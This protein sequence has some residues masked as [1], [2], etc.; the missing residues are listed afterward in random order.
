MAVSGCARNTAGALPN[1]PA[2]WARYG[3]DYGNERFSP[4][5]EITTN[6]VERLVPAYVVQTSTIGPFEGSPIVHDGVLYISTPSDG[7]K[8]VDAKTGDALW[9]RSPISG[10]FRICCGPVNRGVAVGAGLVVIGQ[11]DAKLVALD[12]HSGK[13]KWSTV[14]ADNRDGYSITMAPLIYK[15]SVLIGVAGGE[16]GIRGSLS[17]YALRDGRLQWRWYSTDPQHWRSFSTGNTGDGPARNINQEKADYPAFA[18]A[19]KHG[20]GPIWTTPA[21][22]PVRNAIYLST[23]N[24]WPGLFGRTRP[25]DNLF[26]DCI[27]ALDATSGKLKWYFQETPHDVHDRDAAAPPMLFDMTRNGRTVAAVAEVSKNGRLYILDRDNGRLIDDRLRLGILAAAAKTPPTDLEGGS[28][29]SPLSFNPQLGY[30][31]VCAS[32]HVKRGSSEDTA[33][34]ATAPQKHAVAERYG[35]ASAVDVGHGAIVWQDQFDLG[36]VGGSVSTAG[37][38]TFFG[39]AFGDFD[40]VDTQTGRLLWQFQ[41]GA[42]V[43]APPIV[44]RAGDD[45]FVAVASGGN[46]QIG[47]PYGDALFVFHLGR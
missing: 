8:A 45:E 35:L 24:P 41:T 37:G 47:T 25:G 46:R 7:I 42:G 2:D 21:I 29:W 14:V 11:L 38:L 31:I 15:A 6:N 28:N 33:A 22:D 26:T 30:L 3:G 20:G 9:Q 13:P 32:H 36:L 18:D 16:F 39:E 44:F 4:L 27:V 1:G 34:Q 19:W 43:N 23:G 17:S 10:D 5:D 40:A 12:A